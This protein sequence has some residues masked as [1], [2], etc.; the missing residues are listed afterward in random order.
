MH[1]NILSIS[2]YV[3][4]LAA[5]VADFKTK[6]KVIGISECRIRT[7]RLSLSN[8]N[9]DSYTYEYIPTKPSK[10]GTLL[11]IDKTVTYKLEKDQH[12]NKPKEIESKFVNVIENK[13]KNVV[14][15]CIY[16]HPKVPIKEFLNHFWNPFLLNF[17]FLKREIILMGD[18]N[19]N[20][21][22]CNTDKDTS[23]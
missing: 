10:G 22:N 1:L 9:I 12:H 8:I 11:Y 3:D 20:L 15:D 16:K 18:F 14:I 5:L 13:K 7:G 4:D 17:L 6:P 2:C 21:L 19:I 23:D